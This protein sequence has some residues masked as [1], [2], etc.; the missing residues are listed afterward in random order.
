M[1]FGQIVGY[2][3]EANNSRILYINKLE[4]VGRDD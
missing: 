3:H 1:W 2:I 4:P